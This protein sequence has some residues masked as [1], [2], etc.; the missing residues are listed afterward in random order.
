MGAAEKQAA[1]VAI[2]GMKRLQKSCNKYAGRNPAVGCMS[3]RSE[4][5]KTP[6]RENNAQMRVTVAV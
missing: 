1:Q 3:I 6:A 4:A 2:E 5:A